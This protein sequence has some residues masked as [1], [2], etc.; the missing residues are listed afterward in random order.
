MLNEQTVYMNLKDQ[1]VQKIKQLNLVGDATIGVLAPN[2]QSQ[3]SYDESNLNC[4][5]VVVTTQG[6]KR[7]QFNSSTEHQDYW[8]PVWV[9]IADHQSGRE[10]TTEGDYQAWYETIRNR[11]DQKGPQL[12]P[13]AQGLQMP[14]LNPWWINWCLVDEDAKFS[15]RPDAYQMLKLSMHLRFWLRR[16]R[17]A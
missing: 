11:F 1:V 16:V 7:V 17:Q 5:A 14:L 8:F 2:I 4:P 15:A 12:P 6:E 3:N 13:G 9:L 10:Q